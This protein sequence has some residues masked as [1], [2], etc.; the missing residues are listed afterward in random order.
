MYYLLYL[1]SRQRARPTRET[2][3]ASERSKHMGMGESAAGRREGAGGIRDGA[4][5]STC[6]CVRWIAAAR[7]QPS[8]RTQERGQ[9]RTAAS[10]A[11]G[12]PT[13]PRIGDGSVSCRSSS[14]PPSCGRRESLGGADLFCPVCRHASL[15]H[16]Q[17]ASELCVEWAG[18]AVAVARSAVSC[19]NLSPGAVIVMVLWLSGHSSP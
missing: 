6:T 13:S 11:G 1:F 16:L 19:V 15:H 9:A 3:R 14:T 17:S 18:L 12:R 4:Q 2:G 5:K 7:R 10:A 8:R